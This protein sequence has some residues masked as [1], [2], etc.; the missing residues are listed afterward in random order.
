MVTNMKIKKLNDV[1]GAEIS[2]LDLSKSLCS[3]NR[4]TIL[5][6]F[7]E[8]HVLVFRSQTLSK[9]QQINFTQQFGELEEHVGRL[10]D[11]SRY[12]IV[13]T[14]TNLDPVSGKPTTAPHT[15]GNYFW[16]TDK[17]YH[18]VPSLMTLLYAVDVPQTGGD[19]LFCNMQL[20][21][22]ALTDSEKES[23]K[24]LK[25][26]HSWEASRRNTGN[27][28]ASEEQ[29]RERPPVSHPLVRT[30][31][32][33]KNKSLYLGM[34]VGHIEGMAEDKSKQLLKNLLA[35]STIERNIYRHSWQPGDL[36]IWDNRCLLHKADRNYD[37][38][39][40]P[41]V[42]HRTVVRGTRPV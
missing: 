26:V 17:S 16:H 21:Y 10:P 3:K 13:H 35:K 2:G 8:H 38:S 6:A 41:R 42:L 12:P 28:P 19:T 32:V 33:T 36:V 18:A 23:L 4:D 20:A 15:H 5:S 37:M 24:S 7:N 25:A 39:V 1:A 22:K 40:H 11:G 9:T 27:I 34:H 29:K 30:H 31:P 14:V